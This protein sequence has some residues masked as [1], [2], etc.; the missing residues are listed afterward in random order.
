MGLKHF[1]AGSGEGRGKLSK[2]IPVSMLGKSGVVFPPSRKTGDLTKGIEYAAEKL[3]GAERA[4]RKNVS[5]EEKYLSEDN[6]RE[7]VHNAIHH[8][9]MD[10]VPGIDDLRATFDASNPNHLGIKDDLDYIKIGRDAEGIVFPKEWHG[11][12]GDIDLPKNL[13]RLQRF[14]KRIPDLSPEHPGFDKVN[15][16]TTTHETSHLLASQQFRS[17]AHQWPMARLHVH[18]VT[19]LFGKKHGDALKDWYDRYSVEY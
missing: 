15:K 1:T 19:S 4:F 7:L 13:M 18:L 14:G 11:L 3:Y 6:T 10:E 16:F 2:A 8:P 5:P 17:V 12:N 9:A